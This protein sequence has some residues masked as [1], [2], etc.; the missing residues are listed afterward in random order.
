MYQRTFTKKVTSLFRQGWLLSRKNKSRLHLSGIYLLTLSF[1]LWAQVFIGKIITLTKSLYKMV[2]SCSMRSYMIDSMTT[3]T[4]L[5][6]TDS[7]PL[8]FFFKFWP[9]LEGIFEMVTSPA[10]PNLSGKVLF[11]VNNPLYNSSAY[12]W[13][14][15]PMLNL[16]C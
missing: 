4:P 7:H 16:F 12:H 11:L 13:Y 3:R 14:R 9:V 6:W 10:H 5:P 15:S 8:F 1:P 2:A